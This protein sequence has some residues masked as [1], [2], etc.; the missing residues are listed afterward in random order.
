MPGVLAPVLRGSPAPEFAAFSL[1][2]LHLCDGNT[3]PVTKGCFFFFQQKCWASGFVPGAGPRCGYLRASV[4]LC[5]CSTKAA[6]QRI[7]F[8]ENLFFFFFNSFFPLPSAF[9]NP[10]W[11][12]FCLWEGERRSN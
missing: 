4:A 7:Y 5:L 6:H 2:V 3:P 9:P 10:V 12:L 11:F 8:R 1:C